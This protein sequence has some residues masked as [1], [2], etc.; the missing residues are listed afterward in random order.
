MEFFLPF[1]FILMVGVKVS[2]R[3]IDSAGVGVRVKLV[4]DEK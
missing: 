1:K 2:P 4:P 3:V